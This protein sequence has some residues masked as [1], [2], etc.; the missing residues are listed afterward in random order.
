MFRKAQLAI[1]PT[2][3]PVIPHWRYRAVSSGVAF[4]GTFA[5]AAILLSSAELRRIK[6]SEATLV[7]HEADCRQ[8]DTSCPA[9]SSETVRTEMSAK[10]PSSFGYLEFD[11]DPDAPG[12][13]PGFGP[14]PPSNRSIYAKAAKERLS[15]PAGM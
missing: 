13:I 2:G 15:D 10:A 1:E 3:S 9:P 12:G 14:L 4:A 8:G 11:W 7:S 6:P 5:L